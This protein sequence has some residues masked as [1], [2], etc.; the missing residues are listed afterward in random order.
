MLMMSAGD[1]R[2]AVREFGRAEA[3]LFWDIDGTLLTTGRAGI[4]AWEAAA[5][6]FAGRPVDLQQMETAG[7]TDFA[8]GEAILERLGLLDDNDRL[9]RLI[10]RYEEEL[11][12]SLPRR[13][14]RVLSGVREILDHLARHHPTVRSH[15]MTGNTPAGAKVKL[16]HYGLAKYFSSGGGFAL[17][18]SDRTL[19]AQRALDLVLQERP[20][21]LDRI[22]V[23]G[24]TPHDIR[25]GRYLGV[26]T[27]AVGT[28]DYSVDALL[29]YDP[30][31]AIPQL[32]DPRAFVAMLNAE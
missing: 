3:L 30:W 26:K 15:L 25:S 18:T 32:P 2:Y 28:G 5:G 24:D 31:R 17:D 9:H 16:N 22:F 11:P 27:I 1:E 20:T 7:F 21:P 13:T 19:I 29:T 14:G 12:H 8:I 10:R 6:E 4:Y 23:I